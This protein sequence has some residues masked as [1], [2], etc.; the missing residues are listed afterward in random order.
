MKQQKLI[1][2]QLDRKI[3]RFKDLSDMV[4]PPNGWIYS[5]RKGLNMS[6]RQLGN[7]LSIT[8]QSVREMEE[9]E[10]AGTISLK[11]LKQVGAALNMKFIYGFIP[12]DKSLENMIRKRADEIATQIVHRTSINMSLED[13]KNSE[14][15]L[16]RAIKE[17]TDEIISQMPKYLWD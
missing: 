7:R 10:K 12:E 14:Q 4:V 9:R 8:A 13:Q 5:V 15:R 17:K 16:A 1:L 6:L 2:E 3:A 11:V